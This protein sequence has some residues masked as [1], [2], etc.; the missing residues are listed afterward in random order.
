MTDQFT[1]LATLSRNHHRQQDH[2]QLLYRSHLRQCVTE[3][4]VHYCSIRTNINAL[5]S[6]ALTMSRK[7][8][9]QQLALLLPWPESLYSKPFMMIRQSS[10][11]AIALTSIN[12]RFDIA[13]RSQISEGSRC[14]A[15]SS[16]QGLVRGKTLPDNSPKTL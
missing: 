11:A 1:A 8:V 4:V 12:P 14:T 7:R 5:L 10:C 2:E 3:S 6:I 9:R 15:E 13:L 16:T